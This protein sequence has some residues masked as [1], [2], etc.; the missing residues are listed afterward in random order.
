MY[1][2][3]ECSSYKICTIESPFEERC[4]YGTCTYVLAYHTN[5]QL[6][7]PKIDEPLP[8][9]IRNGIMNVTIGAPVYMIYPYNVTIVCNIID[10]K[11]PITISWYRNGNLD[12]S[13]KNVS[14][15]FVIDAKDGDIFTCKATNLDGLDEK[16]TNISSAHNFCVASHK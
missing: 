10:G 15:Y 9:Y 5:V 8:P 12:E 6:D 13:R 1:H 7:R 4:Y 11:P 16:T 2:G 14:T 3:K